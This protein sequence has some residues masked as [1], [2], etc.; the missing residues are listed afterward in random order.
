MIDQNASLSRRLARYRT[1][2]HRTPDG[3]SADVLPF[4]SVAPLAERLAAAVGGDVRVSAAG[5]VV[6]CESPPRPIPLDR[7]RLAALPGGPP[8]GAPLVCLDTETTGL[9]TAAGTVAFLVG[10]GWWNGDEFRQA[11]LLVPDHADEAAMLAAL[12][13]LIQP[14]AWLV[15]YN[16][17]GFDW[18]LLVARYRMHGSAAPAHAGHL[19]LLPVVRRLFR[20]RM[21]DAR[22]RTA[23]EHLLGIRR[24]GDVEGWEI[25]G[26][27]LGFLLGGPA[28]PLADVVR[29]NDQDV[30]SLARLLGHLERGLGDRRTWSL[31]HPGDLAGL[32]RAFARQGRLTDA[33]ECLDVAVETSFPASPSANEPGRPPEPD[34]WSPQARPTFGARILDR[35]RA[36]RPGPA[37]PWTR[38]RIVIERARLQRRAGDRQAAARSWVS[39]TDRPGRTGIV[40]SIELAKFHEHHL[41]D[42]PG[43]L[44]VVAAG[45]SQ[46]ERRRRLGH[47]EADLERDLQR[48]MTR[49]HHRLARSEGVSTRS[50]AATAD[51]DSRS[52]SMA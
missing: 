46:A 33:L 43:A 42:L 24:H 45:L 29:H 18:P 23:E 41:R 12:A 13:G 14:D 47:A 32:A 2:V 37:G 9:A 30:R 39:L 52:A 15:T 7:T 49:L 6:W 19:D 8:S 44:R 31:S 11:Q 10:I 3:P 1:T 40:A 38:D 48:R 27:Y 34:W 20:H 21:A 16:G 17:R 51:Q 22:L 5:S 28:E 35:E 4:P 36:P 26:R 50:G 25:P